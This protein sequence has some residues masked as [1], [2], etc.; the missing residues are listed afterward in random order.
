MIDEAA[1]W[2]RA[3]AE[4]EAAGQPV[5]ALHFRN[6]AWQ[7]EGSMKCIDRAKGDAPSNGA[8]KEHESIQRDR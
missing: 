1:F 2:R 4:R 6:L 7:A 5:S 8:E 3:A